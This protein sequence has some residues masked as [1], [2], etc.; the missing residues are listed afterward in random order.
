MYMPALRTKSDGHLCLQIED[1][2]HPG[3]L[4]DEARSRSPTCLIPKG[5]AVISCKKPSVRR[6]E[7][8]EGRAVGGGCESMTASLLLS[9]VLSLLMSLKKF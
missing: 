7:G 4:Q 6:E 1:I 9:V 2:G 5:V 8:L 3:Q